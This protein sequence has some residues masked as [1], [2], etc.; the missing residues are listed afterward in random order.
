MHPHAQLPRPIMAMHGHVHT[1]I[2][3]YGANMAIDAGLSTN[4]QR[5][6]KHAHRPPNAP[7]KRVVQI[8][9]NT[10]TWKDKT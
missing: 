10:E 7:E 3:L 2:E 1:C 6:S 9:A 8:H 4:K 5:N